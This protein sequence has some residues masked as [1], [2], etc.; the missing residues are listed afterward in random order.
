LNKLLKKG[1]EASP[2]TP[3]TA[4]PSTPTANGNGTT[5]V[6]IEDAE[7]L[8][9]VQR[10]EQH[11]ANLDEYSSVLQEDDETSKRLA[12][13]SSEEEKRKETTTL[14]GKTRIWSS[15]N[16]E[17]VNFREKMAAIRTFGEQKTSIERQ[18]LLPP[19]FITS[20][21]LPNA[22]NKKF[23]CK[24]NL[25]SKE[26]VKTLDCTPDLS[27]DDFADLFNS[28]FNNAHKS[29]HSKEDWVFKAQG[30]AEYIYGSNK[31]LEFDYVR[32]CLKRGQEVVLNL[33]DRDEILRE[34]DPHD[35]HLR[36]VSYDFEYQ[37]SAENKKREYHH[38]AIKFG[39]KPWT[40]MNCISMWDIVRPFRIKVNGVDGLVP[41][42]PNG[43]AN[44]SLIYV[45]A[46]LFHG[47]SSISSKQYTRAVP[48]T[49]EPRWNQYITFDLRVCDL[50]RE[51]IV[52]FTV[53]ERPNFNPK[54]PLITP[55]YA[56]VITPPP[57]S[58]CKTL[59]KDT[60]IHHVKGPIVDYQ[61]NLKH[62]V[63]A[64]RMW[65][66]PAIINSPAVENVSAGEA[67]ND[68]II[69]FT[70]DKY[71]LPV[72][73]PPE[74][75]HPPISM[76][77]DL[78][79]WEEVQRKR[80]QNEVWNDDLQ[81]KRILGTDPLHEMTE[82]EKFCLWENRQRLT[83]NPKALIKFM[84]SVPWH[85]GP[86]AVH[87]AHTMMQEWTPPDPIDALELLDYN[88]A[89]ALVRRYAVRRLN[90]LGDNELSDFLLQLVQTL[91]YEPYHDSSLARFLLQRGLRSTHIVGHI[92][93]WHLKAE[94]HVP[95]VRE[96]HGLLLEEYL[97]NCGSHRRDLMKQNGIIEQ[98]FSL[99]MLI[100]RT[101]KPDQIEVLRQELSKLRHPP[102]FKLPLSPRME[103]KAII[104]D[105]CKVMDSAKLPLWLVF[106]NADPTGEPIYIIFKAGD[107][108]RQDL[109]TLQ[110]LRITDQLWKKN[111][112][113]LHLQPYGC[114]CL[115]DNIGMIEVVLNADTIA[116]ITASRGGASAA[117]SLDPLT[118]W[119]KKYNGESD[120]KWE[121]CVNNFVYS[122]AGYC[123]A[124]YV[125]GIGDRHNDNIMLT[126]KGDLFHIDFGHFLGHFKTF[127][128][129]KRE[130][131]PF[132]FT[133]MYAHVM[134][135]TESE[136]FKIYTDLACRAYQLMREN[137][138]MFMTL[139][140]LMLATGIPELTSVEDIK[141]LRNCLVLDK[142]EEDAR[143]H[144][145]EQIKMSL[146]NMRARINDAV[147]IIAHKGL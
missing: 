38:D 15:E 34:V 12:H 97:M 114:V 93:F 72:V 18:D 137:G 131:T 120:K 116:N 125:L 110:I 75:S 88:F 132:V 69:S 135:G 98:L 144:F 32:R 52:C 128:G 70:M 82:R 121:V 35:V 14:I 101:K 139:F 102:K 22:L 107:D 109:L 23:L 3:N 44:D 111:G 6:N 92:L 79:E 56:T 58:A 124:T 62:G 20:E 47:G 57:Q 13:E 146:G 118:V 66:G 145:V 83:K 63:I 89:D 108:L 112:L 7:Y 95:T 77:R 36:T 117:F 10:M 33:M 104:P 134:N 103:V 142:N 21:P 90:E 113:D 55:S 147:H 81:L 71:T 127:A 73:F 9:A 140:T 122:C 119:L 4:S 141:W 49:R 99:A 86:A 59:E 94:M 28:K 53:Y 133:P 2:G 30:A 123:T 76:H 126:K 91:K 41:S 65:E 46:Q 48:F 80:F 87:T 1:G 105:K 19:V 26:M 64:L 67:M 37:S 138:H 74:G 50:P 68:V 25:V 96:R 61:S 24:V 31:M 129:I 40:E 17:V 136:E 85:V 39:R 100:K 115:G 60:A 43:E 84:L 106:E 45:V 143:N 29:N 16:A 42:N 27:A 5:A 78:Q 11:K 51:T 8:A 130:T 54:D